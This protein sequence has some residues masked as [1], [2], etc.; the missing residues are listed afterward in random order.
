M[1][2][3]AAHLVDRVIPDV[4][5][6]QRVLSLPWSLR[7]LLAFDAALLVTIVPARH[8]LLDKVRRGARWVGQGAYPRHP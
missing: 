8:P 2:D 6:R 3:L 7:Y 5:V 4:P 1:T